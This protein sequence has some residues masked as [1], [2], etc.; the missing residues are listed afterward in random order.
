[1]LRG[2]NTTTGG[3]GGG[4]SGS[5]TAGRVAKFTG[6]SAVGDSV[7]VELGSA[8]G[9]GASPDYINA[10]L[11]VNGNIIGRY[12]LTIGSTSLLTASNI[13]SAASRDLVLQRATVTAATIK[14]GAIATL[15]GATPAA[16]NGTYLQL[17][18]TGGTGTGATADIVVASGAVSAVVLRAPGNGYTA[19]DL[20]TC[21][22]LTG[23]GAGVTV[24]T[25]ATVIS[26]IEGTANVTTSGRLGAFTPNP[27]AGLDIAAGGGIISGATRFGVSVTGSN[28]ANET[29]LALQ[30]TV[31]PTA[32]NYG[33]WV[34]PQY[35]LTAGTINGPTI[36]GIECN[37][38][39]SASS[40][41]TTQTVSIIGANVNAQRWSA[42]DLSTNASS[43][44]SAV[45]G[46]A[47]IGAS[48]GSASTASVQAFNGLYQVSQAAH[49]VTSGFVY[50]GRLSN[51]GTT[52]TLSV[53]GVDTATF[54]NS[55][56]IGTLY[57]LRLPSITNTG[58]ITTRY[59][60][61]QEDTAAVNQFAG[62][63]QFNNGFGSAAVAYGT[64]AWVNFNGGSGATPP[65]VRASGNVS[66]VT[67]TAVG[68]YVVN[69]TNAMPD[70]NFVVS[71][72][73]QWGGGPYIIGHN[74]TF[75]TTSVNIVNG[76]A[77]GTATDV[78][79]MC[80]TITR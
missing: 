42:S 31:N 3:G 6:A 72:T 38:T 73:T 28:Q 32:S 19:G 77:A 52:T 11:D 56:T 64:R 34:I 17:A 16:T 15:T 79:I 71:A 48:T 29:F 1:M 8:I 5:G 39:V 2:I 55:G 30:G 18:L 61:S 59:G 23:L 20:L 45:R 44:V 47:T 10:A 57:G 70:T 9:I 35:D 68:Q 49:T 65:S 80:V 74:S 67:D 75:T 36:R 13:T 37:P 66:S 50:A 12:N 26:D 25:V 41:G 14:A 58:T 60:I 7:M 69:M 63:M 51:T 33:M 53:Y 22:T 46:T 62:T 21:P 78:A 43:L 54:T 27:R 24:A 76:I 40:A 4:I